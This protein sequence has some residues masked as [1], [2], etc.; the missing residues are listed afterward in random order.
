MALIAPDQHTMEKLESAKRVTDDGIDFW[1]ARDLQQ[2]LGYDTWEGFQ[3]VIRR[4]ED[5]LRASNIEPSHQIRQRTKL[6]GRGSG[7]G[8]QAATDYFLSR[9]ASYLIAL[10]GDP[11]KVEVAAAQL[12]FATQTRRSELADQEAADAKRLSGRERVTVAVKRI[13]D[14]AK[15]VGVERFGLFHDARWQGMY[16]ASVKEIERR[17]GVPE[18]ERLLDR[19][20]PLELSAHEFQ[21]NLA[22]EKILQDGISG[23][24]RAIATNRAV[25]ENVRQTMI[26]HVGHGPESLPLEPEPIKVVRKRVTA[27]LRTPKNLPPTEP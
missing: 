27:K 11:S 24:T 20:G 15:D 8:T 14:V 1:F 23:E 10:N 17:K 7:P 5:A 22:R 2:I 26:N 25:A 18:G 16:N 4:A 6:V 13:N 19:A 9:G 3:A 12:Y 21:M